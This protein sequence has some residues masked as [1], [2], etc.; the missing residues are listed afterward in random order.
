MATKHINCIC[1]A[2]QG[3]NEIIH[4][5]TD[6]I[7][8]IENSLD[9]DIGRN[10]ISLQISNRSAKTYFS[11]TT[12][13]GAQMFAQ[14]VVCHLIYCNDLM[15]YPYFKEVFDRYSADLARVSFEDDG[16]LWDCTTR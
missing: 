7:R 8:L 13:D 1:Y 6:W 4:E 10:H 9:E 2:D 5:V 11:P 3:N 14:Y 12:W 16:Y 15:K